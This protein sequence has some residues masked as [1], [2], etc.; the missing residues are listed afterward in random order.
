VQP[1]KPTS[2]RISLR[3]HATNLSD[4]WG[5]SC[6]S[7]ETL[8]PFNAQDDHL[9][10]YSRFGGIM[11]ANSQPALFIK[12]GFDP[13]YLPAF[14]DKLFIEGPRTARR[15]TNFFALLL[16]AT[17]IATYG[18]LSNSTATVIGAM[19]VA[20]LME[21]MMATAAAVVMGSLPRAL[22]ALAL[23]GTGAVSV[24]LFSY[25]L[26]WV[27]P[28]VT[29]SFLS[30]GEITSRIHPGLYALLT[31][32]GAGAA[33]AFIT[34]RAEIAEALGGVAI[35]IALVPPLCVI[36][37]SLQQG[38]L[39]AAAG[40]SLLFLTNFLAI[41]LAGGVVLLVLGLGKSVVSQEQG[42]FRR[43]AFLLIVMGL[44]LVTIPLSLTAYQNVLSAR[45]NAR[46]TAEVQNWLADTS[47]RVDTV[48]ANDGVV[49]VTVEGTGQLKPAQQLA[50]QLALAL[51]HPVV[52][53]LRVLPVQRVKSSNP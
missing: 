40:A 25:L 16:F 12:L 27:V 33:G 24:I 18:V 5:E 36:G 51:G 1:K 10:S 2:W 43:R 44:L 37:I 8:I 45:E 28:D 41:L 9:S 50:N 14:E 7:T 6:F 31:A 49:M 32:L 22:R 52:V 39:D 30:D 29:I 4:R 3:L 47:Y 35:A 38:Q 20:P 46:A 21:P 17:I 23:A 42:R 53:E 13:A 11:S 15:L 48:N 19:L 26:S 34:S